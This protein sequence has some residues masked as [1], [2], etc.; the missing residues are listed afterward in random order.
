MLVCPACKREISALG[1]FCPEC[2]ATL[3]A[4]QPPLAPPPATGGATVSS[5]D[6]HP[7]SSHPSSSSVHGRFEPGTRLGTR[8]RVVGLLGRGGMGEV[9][10]AD[11]LEL[12]Q[13]VAL[14]FLPERVA[15]NATDLARLRQEVRVAR[16][17]AHPNVCRT[18]D[19]S[20]A[21]GQ[22]F[23]VMEYVDGEDLASVLRRLGRP[24]AD[25]AL[26][27]ARQL[28]LGIGAAHESGVLHRDLKPANIMIDGRGRVR[29]TDFGLAGTAEEIAAEGGTA[30]TPA[31]MAPEQLRSGTATAQSDIFSLGLVLY[32][33]FTGKRAADMTLRPDPSR[34]DSDSSVQ[35]PSSLVAGV[36]PAVE[37]VILRCLERDP[38]R[39]PQSAYAVYGALPGG[40]PLAA[41]VAAGET[42]SPELVANAGVEGSVRPLYAGI[43]VL[44]VLLG[45][46]SIAVIQRPLFA[47]LGRSPDALSVR[48][49]EI[50][51]QATGRTL[52]RY[53]SL[54]FRYARKDSVPGGDSTAAGA[55][56]LKPAGAL[57]FWRRWSPVPLET[58]ELHDPGSTLLSPPQVYPGSGSAV[59]DPG[60]RL[61]ALSIV[62]DRAADSV[63]AGAAVAA[64]PTDWSGV[65]RA[66]GRD[67]SRVLPVAPPVHLFMGADTVAAWA[68]SDSG[69]P[70]TTI[71]AAAVRGR[72]VGMDTIHGG[73]GL[74][75][76]TPRVE[77][78]PIGDAQEWA[79]ILAFYAIPLLG[80]IVLARRNVRS[81]RVDMRGAL[82]VGVVTATLYVLFYLFKVNQ[83]ELGLLRV[84]T[85][86][87]GGSALGH[88]LVHG[89]AITLAYL[90]IEP[91]VRRLWPRVL[92]TWAR[93][94]SGRVRDP[95]VGRD[96]LIGS[97]VGVVASLVNLFY[98]HLSRWLGLNDT[99]I[100]L[101][102][103]SLGLLL[104]SQAVLAALSVDLALGTL[105]V[106]I[107]FTILVILRFVL[108]N[109]KAAIAGVV[110]LFSAMFVD[111]GAKTVWLD[112]A[113]S[114]ARNTLGTAVA[115]RFGLVAGMALMSTSLLVSE[116][117]WTT[118]L[119]AWFGQVAGLGGL[120]ILALMGYGFMV[121]V[122]GKSIFQDPLRD[123]VTT[124]VRVKK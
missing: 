39:R 102:R 58:A 90:A 84:L 81:S 45:I 18:Y 71:V 11:D 62:P 69:A 30:G 51:S 9:Y 67:P 66:A 31:Y 36:D 97:A 122:G 117:P 40:D 95:I 119:G 24:T 34:G 82:V 86:V 2:G 98:Q 44:V 48:A 72:I 47:G 118:E 123:P 121:A 57:Q 21:D 41:A 94:A 116:F 46:A 50:M 79:I 91:Y 6:T 37:R 107:Y 8:Y 29:I 109:N 88:A 106:T 13:S 53:S 49:E 33:L 115:L 27:I 10:R 99:A 105:R 32:E 96:I 43:L 120:I 101:P 12:N 70:D 100:A 20:E 78:A 89:V 7:P 42:P 61:L 112:L 76:L 73:K 4:P 19:I 68:V 26:E 54:G 93:L 111:Y 56:R 35:T 65:L 23:V 63:A 14:K 17:I 25:K 108:R 124:S 104:G 52:P 16:Q 114:L 28:C 83:R 15:Q 110:V 3:P 22:V 38:A 1:K 55:R 64:T 60:G 113:I 77:P 92:V 80:S 74:G 87:T 5:P 75:D 103:E 59:L 85:S